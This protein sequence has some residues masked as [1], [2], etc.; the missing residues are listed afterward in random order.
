M[1]GTAGN[2][3]LWVGGHCRF[4]AKGTAIGT[5]YTECCVSP[6]ASLN[7]AAMFC[8]RNPSLHYSDSDHHHHHHHHIAVITITQILYKI[9]LFFN[10]RYS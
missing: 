2:S 3:S 5:H 6:I 1:T 8:P 10:L 9:K 7:P 4:T